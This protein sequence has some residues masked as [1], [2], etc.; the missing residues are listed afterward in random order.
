VRDALHKTPVFDL[1]PPTV[2]EQDW[3]VHC[4]PVGTGAQALQYLAPYIFRVAISN[5]RIL[6]LEAGR[7]TFQYQD[8]QTGAIQVC[9][10]TV[11]EFIRRFLQ[12]ILPDHFVKVRYYGLFGPGNRDALNQ[13]RALLGGERRHSPPEGHTPDATPPE[14]GMRCPKC[15]GVMHLIDTLRP[16]ARFPRNR[17][18]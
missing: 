2:W 16:T 3:V 8:S 5:N 11:E 18:P 1:V 4:E 12:H 10:I 6:R 14:T 15:A 7:V 9:T 17:G 13:A